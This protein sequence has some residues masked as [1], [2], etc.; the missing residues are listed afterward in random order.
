MHVASLGQS[1]QR[2]LLVFS[3]ALFGNA[4]LFYIH[5]SRFL[6]DGTEL[7]D[8]GAGKLA[9]RNLG[10]EKYVELSISPV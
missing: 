6:L 9:C 3:R 5:R 1:S 4:R 2:N 8:G 10:S 7:I